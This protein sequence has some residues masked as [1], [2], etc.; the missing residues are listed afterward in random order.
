MSS[1]A[2]FDTSSMDRSRSPS[3]PTPDALT[4]RLSPRRSP[5]RLLTAAAR[6]GLRPPPTGR[7]RRTTSPIGL[8]PP[9]PTQHRINRS[10]LLPRPPNA[11][12]AHPTRLR[13]RNRA[14][15]QDPASPRPSPERTSARRLHATRGKRSITTLEGARPLEASLR[16][17]W[18]RHRTQMPGQRGGEPCAPARRAAPAHRRPRVA[19]RV[20]APGRGART[21][22]S[23]TAVAR[24]P[25]SPRCRTGTA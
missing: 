9:S 23:R 19:A 25:P 21:E 24:R 11:F 2:D 15:V 7:P 17:R 20:P 3:W 12:V 13:S 14:Q 8:A 5:P 18:R 16:P 4:A 6:G 1:N 10:D 22:G